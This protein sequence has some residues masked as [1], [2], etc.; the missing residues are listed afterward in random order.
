MCC[1]R[2][3]SSIHTIKLNCQKQVALD[4]DI[5]F[6]LKFKTVFIEIVKNHEIKKSGEGIFVHVVVIEW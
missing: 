3:Y 1:W 4:L 2:R 6:S 5:V